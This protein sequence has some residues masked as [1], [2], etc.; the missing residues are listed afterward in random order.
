M[1]F[2]PHLVYYSE[3]GKL[4]ST[5]LIALPH[6]HNIAM[7]ALAKLNSRQIVILTRIPMPSLTSITD[8][9]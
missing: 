8:T 6:I 1:F 4:I 9:K 7:K 3:T 5:A 2:Y